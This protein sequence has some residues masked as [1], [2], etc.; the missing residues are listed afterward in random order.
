MSAVTGERR[1][2]VRELVCDQ[3]KISQESGWSSM[4]LGSR[5]W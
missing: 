3:L 1:D 4:S 5:C 2:R